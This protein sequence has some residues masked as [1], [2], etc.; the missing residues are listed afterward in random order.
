MFGIAEDWSDVRAAAASC[1]APVSIGALGCGATVPSIP[2]RNDLPG[3][4]QDAL[5]FRINR[6]RHRGAG[7][8]DGRRV[9][10]KVLAKAAGDDLH[11]NRR[12]ADGS[13]RD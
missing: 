3:G 4:M 7:L 10:A 1:L 8:N 5:E 9:K 11:T 12:R 13:G 6:C 2:G